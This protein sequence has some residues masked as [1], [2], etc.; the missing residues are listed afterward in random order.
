MSA[1]ASALASTPM[2]SNQMYGSPLM[3]GAPIMSNGAPSGAPIM[4]MPM[5]TRM[6]MQSY[7]PVQSFAAPMQST[8]MPAQTTYAPMQS[9]VMTAAPAQ[10]PQQQQYVY[11]PQGASLPIH[12]QGK[13]VPMEIGQPGVPLTDEECRMLDLPSGC[14]WGGGNTTTTYGAPV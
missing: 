8:Y 2:G 11:A 12:N 5:T 14:I 4:S 1:Q 3:S 7:A 6:P 9:T 10:A 13:P